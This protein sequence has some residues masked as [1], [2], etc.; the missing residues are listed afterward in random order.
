MIVYVLG[1]LRDIGI[2]EIFDV[3]GDFAFPVQDAIDAHPK[4]ADRTGGRP[5]QLGPSHRTDALQGSCGRLQHVAP[6]NYAEL[7]HALG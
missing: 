7:P 6:W 4:P 1:R 3:P 2:T 5:E